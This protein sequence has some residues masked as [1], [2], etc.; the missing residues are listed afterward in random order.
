MKI[1]RLS[2]CDN[3]AFVL[4]PLFLFEGFSKSFYNRSYL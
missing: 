4:F 1:V 3:Q 2:K